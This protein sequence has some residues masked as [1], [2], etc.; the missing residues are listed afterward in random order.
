MTMSLLMLRN[1]GIGAPPR[2]RDAMRAAPAK[3]RRR[4]PAVRA[5]GGRQ[6]PRRWP[7]NATE[8]HGILGSWAALTVAL[9]RYLLS[10]PPPSSPFLSRTAG[11]RRSSNGVRNMSSVCAT[12]TLSQEQEIWLRN[13]KINY[14]EQEF[15]HRNF[16]TE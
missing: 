2:C 13:F 1:T 9:G 5:R 15:L 8:L 4:A 7:R 11:E 12:S 3:A 10:S 14:M 6:C 16:N